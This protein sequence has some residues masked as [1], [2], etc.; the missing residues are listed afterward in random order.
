MLRKENQRGITCSQSLV[1]FADDIVA[2]EDFPFIEPRV[3]AGIGKFRG[4]S[5]HSWFVNR[6]VTTKYPHSFPHTLIPD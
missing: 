4:Y 3:D 1:D 5:L 2:S 6:T